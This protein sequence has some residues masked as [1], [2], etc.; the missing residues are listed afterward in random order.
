ML[1]VEFGKDLYKKAIDSGIESVSEPQVLEEWNVTIAFIK[2][3]DGYVIEL[4]EKHPV[5]A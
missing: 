1:Y 4:M 5:A 2:D 3:P